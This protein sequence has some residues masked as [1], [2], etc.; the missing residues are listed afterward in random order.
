MR[1]QLKRILAIL[2]VVLTV[3]S[4]TIPVTAANRDDIASPQ[5]SAYISNVWASASKS[6]GTVT[7]EFSITGT[8]K[9]T[10]LGATTI[11]IYN[12]SGKVVKSFS[13]STTSGMMGYNQ[14]Y[15]SSSVSWDGAES[16]KKYYAIVF[17]KASLGSGYDTTSYTTEY[18]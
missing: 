1:K 6:G 14:G 5:A 4:M 7:V 15:Y 2:L 3:C 9:M 16:G 8:G 18:T 13:S 10:S 17:Y 12:S 11:A